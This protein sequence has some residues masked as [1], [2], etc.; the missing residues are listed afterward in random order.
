MLVTADCSSHR[1]L[2]VVIPSGRQAQPLL[3]LPLPLLHTGHQSSRKRT[4][5]Q[6]VGHT[7]KMLAMF[8]LV[9]K[10]SARRDSLPGFF[11]QIISVDN[12]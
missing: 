11:R 5:F 1:D 3:L 4:F 10:F 12:E 8:T 9:A 6:C 7:G 2:S